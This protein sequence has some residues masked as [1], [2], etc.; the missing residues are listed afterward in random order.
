MYVAV[1]IGHKDSLRPSLEFMSWASLFEAV[2]FL[3]RSSKFQNLVFW[4][5]IAFELFLTPILPRAEPDRWLVVANPVQFPPLHWCSQ[6]NCFTFKYFAWCCDC[7]K[8]EDKIASFLWEYH[9][10]NFSGVFCHRIVWLLLVPSFT[11]TEPWPQKRSNHKL[12]FGDNYLPTSWGEA[13]L[14]QGS[15]KKPFFKRIFPKPV[16]PPP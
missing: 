10:F 2:L 8:Q 16:D 7:Q 1:S 15:T 5:L 6:T 12:F 11:P 4:P 13:L 3:N 14:P 9:H